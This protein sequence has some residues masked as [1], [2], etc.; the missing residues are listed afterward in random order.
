MRNQ[1]QISLV[2]FVLSVAFISGFLACSNFSTSAARAIQSP[3]E[4]KLVKGSTANVYLIEAGR[5][6]LVPDARTIELL[7]LGPIVVIPDP[8][9]N[10]IPTG[11]R[12]PALTGLI[13][14]SDKPLAL[15]TEPEIFLIQN[16]QKRLLP[17]IET[18]Y[19]LD[20]GD[21]KVLPDAELQSLVVGLPFPALPGSILKGSA[22]E[23]FQIE[24]GKRR[25]IPFPAES[26]VKVVPNRVLNAVPLGTPFNAIGTPAAPVSTNFITCWFSRDEFHN[27]YSQ[28]FGFT[29]ENRHYLPE[30][31]AGGAFS[32]SDLTGHITRVDHRCQSQHCG[33]TNDDNP[34]IVIK[35]ASFEWHRKYGGLAVGET[36]TA[37]YEVPRKVLASACP[38]GSHP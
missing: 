31:T 28:T 35:G 8:E 38:A 25:L 2:R 36:Y 30:I 9:L 11:A 37:F 18:I 17:N 34:A 13:V 15:G 7:D 1:S 29:S 32:L 12:Y 22:P 19:Y 6:R 27:E 26:A 20:L 23:V 3:H 21:I 24:A 16:A 14:K 4:G 33:W 5:K 10:A